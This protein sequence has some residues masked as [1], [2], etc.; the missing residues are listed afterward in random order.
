MSIQRTAESALHALGELYQVV[1]TSSQQQGQ[2]TMSDSENL[3]QALSNLSR[4]IHHINQTD[5][6]A[7]PN[8]ITS[9]LASQRWNRAQMR[10]FAP[11]PP[12]SFGDYDEHMMMAEPAMIGSLPHPRHLQGECIVYHPIRIRT[13]GVGTP[14]VL[15]VRNFDRKERMHRKNHH[16]HHHHH[17][18]EFSLLRAIHQL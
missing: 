1:E 2:L 4:L 14:T 16:H 7:H 13:T 18:R 12:P 8:G 10:P 6:C 9:N 15:P 5:M 11:P 3:V 17:K